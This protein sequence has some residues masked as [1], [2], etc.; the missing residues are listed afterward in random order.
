MILFI[1]PK[2]YIKYKNFKDGLC[3]KI[4]YPFCVQKEVIDTG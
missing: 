3:V 2:K 4:A 1:E